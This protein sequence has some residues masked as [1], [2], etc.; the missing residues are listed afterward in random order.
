VTIAKALVLDMR[1]GIADTVGTRSVMAQ[2]LAVQAGTALENVSRVVPYSNGSGTLTYTVPTG[3]ANFFM[4]TS[5]I[6]LDI[7]VTKTNDATFTLGAQTVFVCGPG[8]KS[9]A[10][11]NTANNNPGH[12]DADVSLFA[13]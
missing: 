12:V 4:F 6:P 7:T 3:A 5:R 9:V 10:F 2:R 1:A 11:A 8:I 13:C